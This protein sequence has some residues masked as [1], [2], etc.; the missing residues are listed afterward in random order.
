MFIS[1]KFNVG[2]LGQWMFCI[3]N[4]EIE[5]GGCNIKG[6]SVY[7]YSFDE[8]IGGDVYCFQVCDLDIDRYK[9][10]EIDR[11]KDRIL[12][13]NQMDRKVG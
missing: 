10:R 5:V 12:I 11:M 2:K 8:L 3:D 1:S 9:G 6:K 4:V 7:L 13:D